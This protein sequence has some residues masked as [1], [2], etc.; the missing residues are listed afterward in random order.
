MFENLKNALSSKFN[1]FK[2]GVKNT[3][4]DGAKKVV[5]KTTQWASDT[6]PGAIKKGARAL[7]GLIKRGVGAAADVASKPFKFAAS[8]PGR[9][10]RAVGSAAIDKATS[11][12]PESI[13]GVTNKA[14]KGAGRAA[15]WAGSLPFK[16]AGKAA[17]G[18]G[19]AIGSA[20][21]NSLYRTFVKPVK[22]AW[23]QNVLNPKN[24]FVDSIRDKF[25]LPQLDHRSER[26]IEREADADARRAKA[27]KDIKTTENM[28]LHKQFQTT[29]RF[30]G[31]RSAADANKWADTNRGEVNFNM[32]DRRGNF[33]P[34][35]DVRNLMA[36]QKQRGQSSNKYLSEWD[37]VMNGGRSSTQNM[38]Q[39]MN[40]NRPQKDY[41]L[42]L[43]NMRGKIANDSAYQDMMNSA[44]N[45]PLPG[46]GGALDNDIRNANAMGA[47]N[48]HNYGKYSLDTRAGRNES[49]LAQWEGTN[50]MPRPQAAPRPFLPE[51]MPQAAPMVGA[52]PM[53][54]PPDVWNFERGLDNAFNQYDPPKPTPPKQHR[55]GRH[56]K[57]K[58]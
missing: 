38:R 27:W 13:Q 49:P 8:L 55:P 16:L 40:Q 42:K 19:G 10:V 6:R 57:R 54:K 48:A 14:L 18:A 51:P 50:P 21:K 47:N 22:H 31:N 24:D 29:G 2:Q 41:D 46:E 37:N 1:D 56:R 9:A 25:G 17:V 45:A 52:A 28:A 23:K 11:Y 3:A 12:L 30:Q 7:G 39:K 20:A 58:K 53:P 36:H 26:K 5:D 4:Y 35:S 33:V 32:T 34:Q 44:A 15:M 43:S